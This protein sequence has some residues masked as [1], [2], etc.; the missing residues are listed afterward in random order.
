MVVINSCS[1]FL[2]SRVTKKVGND[3]SRKKIDKV[4]EQKKIHEKSFEGFFLDMSH[5]RMMSQQFLG[6]SISWPTSDQLE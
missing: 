6:L 2:E 1:V 4:P 5:D 3:D